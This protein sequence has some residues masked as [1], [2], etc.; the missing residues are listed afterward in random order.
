MEDNADGF[1]ITPGGIGT[2][3]EFF[4]ILTLKQLNRHNKPI[5]ILNVNGYYDELLV[6]LKKSS[7]QNFLRE[8]C[9]S[10]YKVFTDVN[11]LLAYMENY[12]DVQKSIKELKEG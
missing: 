3:E 12:N 11:E 4:E 2:F 8:D 9:L 5:A 1:V 10:L 7:E 6:A